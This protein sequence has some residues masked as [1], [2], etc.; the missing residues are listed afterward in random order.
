MAEV[1]LRR[2]GSGIVL[3]EALPV[4]T[5]IRYSR[6]SR[7]GVYITIMPPVEPIARVVDPKPTMLGKPSHA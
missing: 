1:E 2:S 7:N 6:S 4:G 5:R 3:D